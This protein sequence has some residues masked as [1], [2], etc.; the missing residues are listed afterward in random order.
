MGR[1]RMVPEEH[2]TGGRVSSV[3][4][5]HRATMVGGS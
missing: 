3:L 1:D 5:C 4:Q 2:W